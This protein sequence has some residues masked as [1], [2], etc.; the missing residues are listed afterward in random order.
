MKFHEN[1][2]KIHEIRIKIISLLSIM[3][4]QKEKLRFPCESKH[5]EKTDYEFYTSNKS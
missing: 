2:S 1:R 5:A 4:C 3:P